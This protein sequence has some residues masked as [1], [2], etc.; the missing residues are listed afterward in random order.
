MPQAANSYNRRAVN[1]AEGAREDSQNYE[2]LKRGNSAVLVSVSE[3]SDAKHRILHDRSPL[4]KMTLSRATADPDR[5]KILLKRRGTL[6]G[7]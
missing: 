3:S 7:A 6:A 1:K 2:I 4:Q 5:K